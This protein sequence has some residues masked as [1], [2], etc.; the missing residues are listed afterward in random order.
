MQYC[1][2]FALANRRLMMETICNIFA[3][4]TGCYFPEDMINIAHNYAS[5]ENHF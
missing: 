3:L 5:L 2:D 4:N 1:V